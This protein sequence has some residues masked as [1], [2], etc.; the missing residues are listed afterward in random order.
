MAEASV[1]RQSRCTST[2]S[3]QVLSFAG[4]G[5]SQESW[6]H[7]LQTRT[8][9]DQA[10]TLYHLVLATTHPLPSTPLRWLDRV[11]GPS[12]PPVPCLGS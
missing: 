8:T 12:N 7:M 2:G 4:R 10:P 9:R 3:G 11:H 6:T 1:Q 5:Q